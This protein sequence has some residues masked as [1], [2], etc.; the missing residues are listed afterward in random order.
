METKATK[1]LGTST[2][3]K[4]AWKETGTKKVYSAAQEAIKDLDIWTWRKRARKE[5]EKERLLDTWTW[6]KGARKETEEKE[7]W[8]R[9]HPTSPG[10]FL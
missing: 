2:W 6:R 8:S 10:L 3:R 4:G 5:S 1:D 7:K 9:K